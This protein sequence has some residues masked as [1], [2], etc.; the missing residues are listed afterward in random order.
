MLRVVV[1]GHTLVPETI[2]VKDITDVT[3][4]IYRF[5]GATISVLFR[6]S[7]RLQFWVKTYDLI[8]GLGEMI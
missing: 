8:I 6:E 1:L 2:V 7:E 5:P 4:D 3:I